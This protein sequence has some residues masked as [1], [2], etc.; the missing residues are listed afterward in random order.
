MLIRVQEE[1]MKLSLAVDKET[2]CKEQGI[3]YIL[4]QWKVDI[5]IVK[6]GVTQ[7]PKVEDRVVDILLSYFSKYREFPRLYPKRY[8]NT[9][10]V[11]KKE[12]MLHKYFDKYRFKF[13]QPFSGHTEYFMDIPEEL[14]LEAYDRCLKGENIL[15]TMPE[16]FGEIEYVP[17]EGYHDTPDS[18]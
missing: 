7:K 5:K 11:Y 14:L 9:D 3:L 1:R 16:Q 17:A 8:R 18:E 13:D 2:L 12:A 15:E 4:Y 10:K 6:I